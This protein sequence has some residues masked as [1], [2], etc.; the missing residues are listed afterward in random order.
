MEGLTPTG[1]DERQ[2]TARLS[3]VAAVALV[4][5]KLTAGAFS[6][7]LGLVAEAAHSATDF[8]AALLTLF[9]VRVAVRPADREHHYGHG[10][11]EHLAALAESAVLGL[12]SLVIGAESLRRLVE[13]SPA[14]VDVRWWTLAVI[15]VVIGIDLARAIASARA[16]RRL[17]SAALASNALHFASDLAGSVA[18]LIG[19]ALVRAGHQKADAIAALFV[20]VLVVIAAVR[21][22]RRSIDV[23]MD[24]ASTEAEDAV[25]A[26]LAPLPV[27][28]RRV[29]VR[30]AAGFDF[31]DLVIAV[32]PDV[33]VGQAHAVADSVEEAV[34]RTLGRSDVVVHVEPRALEG[35][36]RERVTAAAQTVA[37][38]REIHNVRVIR[39]G[40]AYELSLHVKL[41]PGQ[42]LEQAHEVV[43]RL[44]A[45]IRG[46]VPEVRDIHTH[47]EPLA[48]TDW[49][50]RP[51]PR[52]V[53]DQAA[54]ID[55]VVERLTGSPPIAV[56][57]R[58]A[59]AGR[60]LLL[61]I[62]L[63]GEQP[64][65]VAHRRAGEVEEA[66]RQ[67]CPELVDVIVHT[68]PARE[69]EPDAPAGSDGS[70]GSGG[71]G[72]SDAR[73]GD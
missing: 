46:A 25:R 30:H 52:E 4:A 34:H 26:A 66:V 45:A 42:P 7:S 50:R 20:A 14:Q 43:S 36:L 23:L 49:A 47:M 62:A 68:E 71:S 21:L 19:L 65:R 2:R 51:T 48:D 15:V 38:V 57:F 37:D 67:Q 8:V 31:V 53:A 1:V 32:A 44:E 60:I 56:R 27:E 16:A 28:V 55:D 41:P 70:G 72:G 22:A 11:A 54:V 24:R 18:V 10:K 35:P 59:E 73:A 61:D 69:D 33:A 58:D 9:A 63:A 40:D 29:R 13:S 5:I 17:E 64:L 3:V 39:T 12:V 6:G